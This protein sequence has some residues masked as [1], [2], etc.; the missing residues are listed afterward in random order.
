MTTMPP[1]R[2]SLGARS[3]A[4]MSGATSVGLGWLKPRLLETPLCC[5]RE[6]LLRIDGS[7]LL[8]CGT[9]YGPIRVVINSTLRR[10]ADPG[11]HEIND[12]GAERCQ[13]AGKRET[14]ADARRRGSD[15]RQQAQQQGNT[16]LDADRLAPAARR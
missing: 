14:R 3:T 12:V 9:K 8:Q 13:Q 1:R 2:N 5:S 7:R 15:R 11:A 4:T 16:L 6:R 10:R